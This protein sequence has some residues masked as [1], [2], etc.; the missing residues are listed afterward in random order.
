M[1]LKEKLSIDEICNQSFDKLY[2]H[3]N[4]FYKDSKNINVGSVDPEYIDIQKKSIY[5]D[6]ENKDLANNSMIEIF[7]QVKD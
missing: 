1:K 6:D 2:N 4:S 7:N 5:K 3:L